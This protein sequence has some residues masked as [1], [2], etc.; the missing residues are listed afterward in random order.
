MWV[1]VIDV[2]DEAVNTGAVWFGESVSHVLIPDVRQSH[3][4]LKY[5]TYKLASNRGENNRNIICSDNCKQLFDY[6]YI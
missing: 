6:L 2:L 3:Q 1:D 5:P 4:G